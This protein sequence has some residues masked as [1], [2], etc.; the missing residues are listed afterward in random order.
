MGKAGNVPC[1]FILFFSKKE[2][3]YF[4]NIEYSN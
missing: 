3:M 4:K 1:F 2:G